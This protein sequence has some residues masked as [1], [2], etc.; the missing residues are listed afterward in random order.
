MRCQPAL[1]ILRFV[2]LYTSQIIILNTQR[3]FSQSQF[4][5]GKLTF[6]ALWHFF[7]HYWQVSYHTTYEKW[8]LCT[9][10][11]RLTFTELMHLIEWFRFWGAFYVRSQADYHSNPYSI[12]NW[13][14]VPPYEGKRAKTASSSSFFVSWTAQTSRFLKNQNQPFQNPART[15][16]PE[17]SPLPQ[18]SPVCLAWIWDLE[19]E[20]WIHSWTRRRRWSLCE[21]SRLKWICIRWA[22]LEKCPFLHFDS[23]SPWTCVA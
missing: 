22:S 10:L 12:Y 18:T 8:Q 11:E 4:Y 19:Q 1:I 6:S 15:R 21:L 9:F 20:I 16:R 2:L 23:H 3:L 17:R 5:Y 14:W 13:I 7:L